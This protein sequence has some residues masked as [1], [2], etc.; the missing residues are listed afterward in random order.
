MAIFRK[1]LVL[2]ALLG[3]F[4]QA[5]VYAAPTMAPVAITATASEINCAGMEIASSDADADAAPCQGMTLACIAKMG[6]VS[7]SLVTAEPSAFALPVRF[8][9]IRYVTIDPAFASLTVEPE[10]FPPIA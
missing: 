3:A 7:A 5:A 10:V 6:C 4:G 9:R 1:L 2:I 8:F